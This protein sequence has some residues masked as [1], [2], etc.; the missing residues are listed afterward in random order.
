MRLAPPPCVVCR[1]P[2]AYTLPDVQI[3]DSQTWVCS[4]ACEARL[5]R[6]RVAG[7]S[8]AGEELLVH[9]PISSGPLAGAIVRTTWGPGDEGRTVIIGPVEL[10]LWGLYR[11]REA[12]FKGD[13]EARR[14]ATSRAAPADPRP[15]YVCPICGRS[16][17]NPNDAA[18]AYCGAC[19][20]ADGSLSKSPTT[21]E[22]AR[23]QKPAREPDQAPGDK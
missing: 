8:T 3:T 6:S 2:G 18:N 10:Q 1:Q 17:W 5:T 13:D 20:F 21:G 22:P 12:A 4:R 15:A 9:G 7:M 16:S 14:W 11:T 19:G 23:P